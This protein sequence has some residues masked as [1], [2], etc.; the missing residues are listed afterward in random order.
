MNTK[1]E[2]DADPA[3]MTPRLP[4]PVRSSKGESIIYASLLV[5]TVAALLQFYGSIGHFAPR[6]QGFIATVQ[7]GPLDPQKGLLANAKDET[8]RV[9]QTTPTPRSGG[10]EQ[11]SR[12]ATPV[13]TGSATGTTK[14]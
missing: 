7:A 13:N 12:V 5:A 14:G 2:S 10:S 8:N 3:G 6:A 4:S 1:L 9:D 11:E